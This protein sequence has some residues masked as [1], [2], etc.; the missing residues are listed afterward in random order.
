MTALSGEKEGG[1]VESTRDETIEERMAG[2]ARELQ[3]QLDP[4]ST[5]TMAADLLVRNVEGCDAASIL[6]VYGKRRVETPAASD[7]LAATGDRLQQELREGP[8]L[9]TLW[10]WVSRRRSTRG[11]VAPGS[12]V[13]IAVESRSW[14]P[15]TAS[16]GGR[17]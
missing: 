6:L 10:G 12:P 17:T 5:V 7:D 13:M 1:M 14:R 8:A 15:R 9:D 16:F 2:A 4:D 11:A 3:D